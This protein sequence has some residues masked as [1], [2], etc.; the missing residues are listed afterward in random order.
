LDLGFLAFSR[1]SPDLKWK[2]VSLSVDVEAAAKK[3]FNSQACIFIAGPAVQIVLY[4]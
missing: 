3:I 2:G 1:L 4:F